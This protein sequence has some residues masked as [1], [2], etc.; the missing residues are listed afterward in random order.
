MVGY[1]NV[2]VFI[3][4][5]KPKGENGV[6]WKV[7]PAKSIKENFPY[8]FMVFLKTNKK[9]KILFYYFFYQS[10]KK[11]KLYINYILQSVFH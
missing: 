5:I 7:L 4:C 9:K 2:L 3:F 6:E 8:N 1:T 11:K 10:K